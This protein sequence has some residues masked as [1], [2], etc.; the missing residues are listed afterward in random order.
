MVLQTPSENVNQ[1]DD[2]KYAFFIFSVNNVYN[3]NIKIS[4]SSSRIEIKLCR[5]SHSKNDPIRKGIHEPFYT[6]YALCIC[7][8]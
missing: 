8:Q 7:D 2:K 6:K 1:R 3:I 4:I 5:E